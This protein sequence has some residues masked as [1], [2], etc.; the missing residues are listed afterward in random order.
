MTNRLVT[1]IDAHVIDRAVRGD[2]AAEAEVGRTGIAITERAISADAIRAVTAGAAA[3]GQT[4]DSDKSVTAHV[5]LRD[6]QHLRGSPISA[7]QRS[8]HSAETAACV[9][10]I[11]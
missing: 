8:D 2:I 11:L 4:A 7:D 3:A 6:A 10:P 1:A 9:Q 5:D